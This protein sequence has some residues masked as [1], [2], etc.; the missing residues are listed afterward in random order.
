MVEWQN[1]NNDDHK[2]IILY[3]AG[4]E[5]EK[6]YWAYRGYFRI[7]FCV[8]RICHRKFHGIPV[9]DFNEVFRELQKKKNFIVVAA[10]ENAYGEISASLQN[11]GLKEFKD[12]VEVGN[13]ERKLAVLYGNCHMGIIKE[14]LETNPVF[15]REYKIRYYF[16]Q[17]EKIPDEVLEY[18]ELLIVQDIQEENKYQF[19]CADQLCNK[20]NDKCI[21]IKIPNLFGMNIYFPQFKKNR[22]NY[23]CGMARYEI[24]QRHVNQNAVVM[25]D[26]KSRG[27]FADVIRVLDFDGGD[28]N[29]DRLVLENKSV[30]E[31]ADFIENGEVYEDKFILKNL[32]KEIN[33]LMERE[34][35]CDIEISDYILQ[36]YKTKQLFYEPKHPANV[37]IIEKGRRILNLL[38]IEI[39]ESIPVKNVLDGGELFIYGC[40]KRALGITFKQK[41]VKKVNYLRYTL[42]GRPMDLE[43]YIENY[44][45]WTCEKDA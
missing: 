9:F 7:L 4:V 15:V 21:C 17:K 38:K 42:K 27:E 16:L 14:Y 3:G 6:F 32:E 20:V 44:I 41:Y 1:I 12:Y 22:G 26:N 45:K 13:I 25:Y 24:F 29:I 28:E 39:D 8:D 2:D 33:K 10:K 23:C 36:N 18:C 5:G 40:V 30:K 35:K 11:I 34:K 19:L 43:E 37:L 31:I